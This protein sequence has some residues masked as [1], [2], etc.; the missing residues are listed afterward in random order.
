VTFGGRSGRAKVNRRRI[1]IA[2]QTEIEPREDEEV[3]GGWRMHTLRYSYAAFGDDHG[4]DEWLTYHYHPLSGVTVPHLHLNADAD[5]A[6]K[7]LR[8]RHLPTGR[9]SIEDFVQMLVEEF[10]VGPRRP[11]WKRDLDRNRKRLGPTSES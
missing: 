11:G 2:V 7:G 5:W 9:V 8:R 10:G 3:D 4:S 6:S 1:W